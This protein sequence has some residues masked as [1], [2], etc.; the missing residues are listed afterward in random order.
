MPIGAQNISIDTIK[1]TILLDEKATI[2]NGNLL[3]QGAELDT[4]YRDSKILID[5]LKSEIYISSLQIKEYQDVKVPS[6]EAVI[7]ESKIQYA[8]ESDKNKIIKE[9]LEAD[10]KYQ[11]GRK[12]IFGGGGVIIGI[13]LGLA[14]GI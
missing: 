10:V 3:K 1:K 2:I 9:G 4:L 6:L 12:W 11:K 5:S 8:S 14:F 7:L 13:I